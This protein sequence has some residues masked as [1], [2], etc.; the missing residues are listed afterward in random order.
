MLSYE[1]TIEDTKKLKQLSEL[2]AQKVAHLATLSREQRRA[3]ERYARIS[4]IGSSTRIEN[5]VL[6]D[7]AIAWI[8]ETL[9]ADARP[10][11]FQKEKAYIENKFSKDSERSIE[12]VVGCRSMLAIVFTQAGDLF[13]LS[14]STVIGLHKE[15]M[16]FYSPAKPYIGKY[17]IVPNNVIERVE[18]TDIQRDVLKTSDPGPITEAAMRDLVDWYNDTLHQYPWSIA[19]A[20][21]FVFRFLAIHPFQDGN[22]RLGR[23]LFALALLQS[24]DKNLQAI[25]PYI[26]ID[27]HIEQTRMEYYLVL[28]KCSQGKFRQDPKKYQIGFFLRYMTKIISEAIA[29]D[30]DYYVNRYN[31]YTNLADAPKKT[32]ECFQEHPEMRLALKDI[33]GFT[34]FAK[35]TAIHALGVL[36]E[37]GFL[38]KSGRGRAV[39]Y[40]LTF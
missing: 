35:R 2:A 36:V 14:T 18:G 31:S 8:D 1:I 5:A 19:V 26:A 15:L 30:I 20:C 28:R 40:Q 16:Q 13:P 37:Q 33:L 10:T 4:N 11:A 39:K 34:K 24:D 21:E 29:D 6:T 23:A 27:R 22:G 32:L 7:P 25:A 17:K 3:I 38:Q 9:S 12:E